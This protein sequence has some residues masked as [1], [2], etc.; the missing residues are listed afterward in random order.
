MLGISGMLTVVFS[1]VPFFSAGPIRIFN[2]IHLND[3]RQTFGPGL[4]E[5]KCSIFRRSEIRYSYGI[6]L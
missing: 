2:R 1:L 6:S 4:Q 3:S 5:V